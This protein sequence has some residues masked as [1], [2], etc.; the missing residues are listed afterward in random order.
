MITSEALTTPE[1]L[2]D[3][4]LDARRVELALLDDLS[5]AQMLGARAHFL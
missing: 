2:L 1:A 4:L 5:D 3:P